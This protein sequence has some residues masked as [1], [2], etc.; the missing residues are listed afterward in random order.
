M[1]KKKLLFG[2]VEPAIKI[3]HLFYYEKIFEKTER[4]VNYPVI[5]ST[6]LQTKMYSNLLLLAFWCSMNGALHFFQGRTIWN[7]MVDAWLKKQI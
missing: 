1:S 5:K 7:G 6:R 2:I 4:H 3:S